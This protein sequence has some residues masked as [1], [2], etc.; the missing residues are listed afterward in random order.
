[1][2]PLKFSATESSAKSLR[3][4]TRSRASLRRLR[5]TSR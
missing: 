4:K 2:R 1:M 3:Y 5:L